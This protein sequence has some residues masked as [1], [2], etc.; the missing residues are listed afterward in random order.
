MALAFIFN[1]VSFKREKVAEFQ[2]KKLL[3]G[4]EEA[5]SNEL[6]AF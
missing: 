2:Q 3:T 4:I 5:K 1:K 6:S